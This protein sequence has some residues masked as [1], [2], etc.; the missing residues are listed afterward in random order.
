MQTGVVL[1]YGD[2]QLGAGYFNNGR[3]FMRKSYTTRNWTNLEGYNVGVGKKLDN[4]PGAYVSLGHTGSR[5]RVTG[6]Y[7]RGNVTSVGA[8]YDVAKGLVLYTSVDMF[9]FKSPKPYQGLSGADT[10]YDYLDNCNNAKT[11]NTNN[12]GALFVVG[13]K[14]RF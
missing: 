5:R 8:D 13:T 2:Y 6:G 10:T 4:V 12:R 3:S 11:L 1:D 9:D 14:L 7:A